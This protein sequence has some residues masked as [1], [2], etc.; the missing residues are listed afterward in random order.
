VADVLVPFARARLLAKQ[1]DEGERLARRA[2]D[3]Q[4][5]TLLPDHPSLVATLTVVAQSLVA[6]DRAEDARPILEEAV[7]IARARLPEHHSHRAE[8]EA[9]LREL[10]ASP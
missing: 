3:I 6:G 10:S 7:Q 9:L 8:A 5:R 2:L 4:R 1:I